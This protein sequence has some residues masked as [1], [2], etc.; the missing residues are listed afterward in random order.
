MQKLRFL[1]DSSL[2]GL[3]VIIR[4]NLFETEL[5]I[6]LYHYRV[7]FQHRRV[8]N[9][10]GAC[11]YFKTHFSRLCISSFHLPN[12]KWKRN[13]RRT[14]T[15]VMITEAAKKKTA[16][17]FNEREASCVWPIADKGVKFCILIGSRGDV[18][19]H[20]FRHPSNVMPCYSPVRIQR[21]ENSSKGGFI[22]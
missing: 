11:F 6:F 7:H 17:F 4:C 21:G 12:V 1:N 14:L 22:S 2:V 19:H 15:V 5:C 9:T 10:L 16:I 20:R 3:Y 13:E 18:I 8:H